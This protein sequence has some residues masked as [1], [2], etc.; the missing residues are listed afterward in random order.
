[1][2]AIRAEMTDAISRFVFANRI[3]QRQEAARGPIRKQVMLG[4]AFKAPLGSH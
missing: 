3:V 2:E 1:M 4:T